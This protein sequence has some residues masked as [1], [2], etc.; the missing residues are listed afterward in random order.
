M[1]GVEGEKNKKIR[2][3]NDEKCQSGTH[4][5][6]DLAELASAK[7]GVHSAPRGARRDPPPRGNLLEVGRRWGLG[8]SLLSI[9]SLKSSRPF[10][11]INKAEAIYHR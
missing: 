6:G 8:V 5:S 3:A 9:N 2:P 4:Q 7:W 10:H 1:K 11:I